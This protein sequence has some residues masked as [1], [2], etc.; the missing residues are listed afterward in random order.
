[1]FTL[2]RVKQ[3]SPTKDT[4]AIR[5]EQITILGLRYSVNYS[6]LRGNILVTI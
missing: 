1:M 3:S 4:A 6:E 5:K 2:P